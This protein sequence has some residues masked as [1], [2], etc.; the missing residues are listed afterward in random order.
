MDSAIVILHHQTLTVTLAPCKAG[1]EEMADL[2]VCWIF[3]LLLVGD[4]VAGNE[5]PAA[6][7]ISGSSSITK[8]KRSSNSSGRS[9]FLSFWSSSTI[10]RSCSTLSSSSTSGRPRSNEPS[11]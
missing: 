4:E 9:P 10:T 6:A 11:V 3:T 5:I 1:T 2:I 8:L 7:Y